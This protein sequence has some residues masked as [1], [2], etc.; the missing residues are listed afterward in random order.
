MT[1]ASEIATRVTIDS[2]EQFLR[3]PERA[4]RRY[5]LIHGEIV[6]KMAGYLH[7]T[8]SKILFL[9]LQ[10]FVEPRNLGEVLYETR[11]RIG[12]DPYND[13]LPDVSFTA[14]ARVPATISEGAVELIPDLCIEIQSPDDYPREMRE[15]AA[16][17]LENGAQQVWLVFT[18]RRWV[19]VMYPDGTSDAFHIGDM[20]TGGDLL[21]G[22]S[23]EIAKIFA[24]RGE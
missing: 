7:Q 6:E 9:A 10:F 24:G 18:K 1:N 11:H 16:Y 22:F 2:F 13:R 23:I 21:P 14:A 15:K 5:E 17:Y 12:D 19:E 3:Q 8:I 20:L 4:N